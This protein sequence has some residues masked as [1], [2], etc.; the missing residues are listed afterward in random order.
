MEFVNFLNTCH[1]FVYC[2]LFVKIKLLI[3]IKIKKKEEL[4][5]FVKLN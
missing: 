4:N 5:L 2:S 3:T 1:L